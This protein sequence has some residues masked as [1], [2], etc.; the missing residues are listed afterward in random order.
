LTASPRKLLTQQLAHWAAVLDA[1]TE[2]VRQAV[3]QP[4]AE[5]SN[6]QVAWEQ[7][8]YQAQQQLKQV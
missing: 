6:Q 3:Q 8:A 5:S 4:A 7:Q 1:V 2:T